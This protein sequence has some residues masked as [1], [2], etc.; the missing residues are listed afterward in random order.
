MSGLPPE[1]PAAAIGSTRLSGKS[2]S[3]MRCSSARI[4]ARSMTLANSRTLPPVVA[5][6]RLQGVRLHLIAPRPERARVQEVL[7]QFRN[8]RAALAQGR[9]VDGD[10]VEPV[11]QVL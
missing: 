9:Q 4:W 7:D 5:L 1:M 2:S 6:Q 8:I 11:E 10:H 3:V